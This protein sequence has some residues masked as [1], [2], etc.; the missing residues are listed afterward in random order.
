MRAEP[1]MNKDVEFETVARRMR[2]DWDERATKDAQRYVY[3]RDADSDVADF[4]ASGLANYDQ[5]IRPYLPLLL[6]GVPAGQ[7]RVLEIGCGTGRMTRWL[8]AHFGEV[9]ALDVSGEMLQRA[10]ASLGSFSNVDFVQ[11]TGVDLAACGDGAFDLVFSYIVFQ[12][13]PSADVIE[14]YVSE[15][16]RV[17]KPEGCFKFQVNGDRSAAYLEHE[18]NTWLGESLSREQVAAMLDAAGFEWLA[19]EGEGTQYFVV[20]A[21]KGSRTTG[22][23]S[24]W[25]AGEP[26][27]AAKIVAGVGDAVNASWRPMNA[28]VSLRLRMPEG[29]GRRLYFAAYVWPS[30]TAL[31]FSVAAM[32]GER[33]LGRAA[34]GRT[35]D[36]YL[37][38]DVP[39][40]MEAGEQVETV[41]TFDP[42]P[43]EPPALR[44]LGLYAQRGAADYDRML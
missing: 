20:T 18:R 37:E 29:P 9:T 31:P 1:R 16:A 26:W 21:R 4:D 39:D 27:A 22:E 28:V 2:Q 38:F 43:T 11:G 32:I 13:V 6:N 30:E 19:S 34:I 8:A 10:A 41:V 36:A 12:H 23:G 17:L 14:S 7:C 33:A 44:A 42:S 3:T 15:S 40:E 5:L 35:G 24:H 25:L